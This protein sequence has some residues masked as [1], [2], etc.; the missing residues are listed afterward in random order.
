VSVVFPFLPHIKAGNFLFI[1]H[2]YLVE[3]AGAVHGILFLMEMDI[4]ILI[5]T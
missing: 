3:W 2:K 1:G 5:F 4:N